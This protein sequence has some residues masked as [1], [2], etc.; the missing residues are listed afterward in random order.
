MK[1]LDAKKF[2]QHRVLILKK[3]FTFDDVL[4]MCK[5]FEQAKFIA[6]NVISDLL[7]RGLISTVM[8]QKKTASDGTELVVYKSN[9]AYER[10]PLIPRIKSSKFIFAE[11]DYKGLRAYI[12]ENPIQ[13]KPEHQLYQIFDYPLFGWERIVFHNDLQFMNFITFV[14]AQISNKVTI[15]SDALAIFAIKSAWQALHDKYD[16]TIEQIK[17]FQD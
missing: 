12:D 3:E 16:A 6:S 14:A 1:L 9:C 15:G 4:K 10:A 2:I 13:V 5:G 7:D 17:Q 8:G 11:A